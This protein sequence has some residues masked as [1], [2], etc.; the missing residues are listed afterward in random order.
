MRVNFE[1]SYKVIRKL[2]EGGF[3][4]VLEVERVSDGSRFAKKVIK[5]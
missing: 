3:G 2:G 5:R 1:K 4:E